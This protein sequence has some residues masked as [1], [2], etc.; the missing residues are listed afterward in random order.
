MTF[1]IRGGTRA[2]VESLSPE[3]IQVGVYTDMPSKEL[4]KATDPQLTKFTEDIEKFI[5]KDSA[6]GSMDMFEAFARVTESKLEV[7]GSHTSKSISL[8][9]VKYTMACGVEII[10]RD[11][12]HDIKVSVRAQE[13]FDTDL[14]GL[15]AGNTPSYLSPC[16]FEG[17]EEKWIF[18]AFYRG[19]TRFSASLGYKG[20]QGLADVLRTLFIDEHYKHNDSCKAYALYE[21]AKYMALAY[22]Y[23]CIVVSKGS[24]SSQFRFFDYPPTEPD[25]EGLRKL[26]TLAWEDYHPGI[27]KHTPYI[28]LD[29]T[30]GCPQPVEA[31][32][33]AIADVAVGCK[34]NLG[35]DRFGKKGG[36]LSFTGMTPDLQ[37]TIQAL[38]LSEAFLDTPD[39]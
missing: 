33:K 14:W 9:V 29:F 13:P 30:L 39:R 18:P 16:Y 15:A 17:F 12:F 26:I 31:W 19:C 22:G 24:V 1:P 37:K 36:A 32:L 21:R 38:G 3:L 7:V 20:F 34:S 35:I 8:P 5:W 27:L 10:T 4:P 23:P 11:N 6:R 28:T 25:L 2:P